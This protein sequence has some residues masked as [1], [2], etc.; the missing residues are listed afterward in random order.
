M[1]LLAPG[2]IGPLRSGMNFGK[3]ITQSEKGGTERW[4]G[5][6]EGLKGRVQLL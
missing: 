5:E 1:E 3:G 6:A 4:E 2:E